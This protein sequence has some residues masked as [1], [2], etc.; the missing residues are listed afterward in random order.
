M[1]EVPLKEI[2]INELFVKGEKNYTYE[3]PIY[4]RNY[5]WEKDEISAL[6]QDI[7]DSYKKDSASNYY[8]G[9]LV[10]YPKG[11][12]IFEVIDGQQ[13][14]TTIYLILKALN[15]TINNRLTYRARKK[16]DK[17]LINPSD[18]KTDVNQK[19][20]GIIKGYKYAND[21]LN[22]IDNEQKEQFKHFFLN[23]V[24]IIH[25]QVPKDVDLNHYFEVMNS[26][27][28][29]LEK[30]E[31]VKA[32]LMQHLSN[33][34]KI[35]FNAIWEAC[36][37]MNVYVQ[38]NL[39]ADGVF[40]R[41]KF[42][43]DN[44]DNLS[45]SNRNTEK[46]LS[47]SDIIQNGNY[48]DI[49][50]EKVKNDQFQP[51]IDFPN[52]LLIVLKIMR[53]DDNGFN[54]QKFNLDDKFLLEEFE[55][56][57]KFNEQKVKD[58]AYKLLKARF[59]LDNYVVHHAEVDDKYGNNPWILRFVK[60]EG[61]KYIPEN[62]LGN[63]P[64]QDKLVH[65]LSMFEVSF[66]ARQRK[67]YLFYIIDYLTYN[68][69]INK[70]DYIIFVEKLAERYFFNV[71]LDK[72]KLNQINTPEPGSFDSVI[73]DQEAVE[74]AKYFTT[75]L[76]V[77]TPNDF[78][79]IYGNGL[80]ITAGVP[81]FVFNYLDFKIWKYYLEHGK[82]TDEKSV[83][84]K[85]FFDKLGCKDFG[86]KIFDEFY[87]SRTRRS[88]EHF[89]PQATANG[90]DGQLDENQINCFGNF[91][92]ISASA[93]SMGSNWDPQTKID[94]YLKD[95]SGKVNRVGVSSLKF[96]I[97]MQM[98]KDHGKWDFDK[99]KQHQEKMVEMLLFE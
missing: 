80:E 86:L 69:N 30:H 64:E 23:N 48:S 91:A 92:M 74:N 7:Y 5:A 52:F 4:Q 3:V 26:R 28:E 82:G 77:K 19:D 58:F 29:Q 57:Y 21:A 56:N 13:R 97:M 1:N 10:S 95:A 46:H 68:D 79:E 66:T 67:N 60:K 88:L 98:C 55:M 62:L 89:Y 45:I 59:F 47:I 35:K 49:K 40:D 94:H 2:N 6:V 90:K 17:T 53:L 12:N 84:R 73:L 93:N 85:N 43:L 36:S 83:A 81:L 99:I 75:K 54:P 11:D 32:K 51:I 20:Q 44:F 25:Y 24:H 41:D 22:E 72:T 76:N 71:Y 39:N 96:M 14:L 33:D 61:Y 8:I 37:Q 63:T 34:D 18:D 27:G 38:H 16:S 50:E 31:I 78:A 42:L 65:L 87:F 70:S 9:T 15:I